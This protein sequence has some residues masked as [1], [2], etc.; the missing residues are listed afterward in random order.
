[1]VSDIK[2]GSKLLV[3]GEWRGEMEPWEEG[4]WGWDMLWEE[5]GWGG[6]RLWEEGGWG[7]DRLWE[8][9]GWGG[10]LCIKGAAGER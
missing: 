8:E 2:D 10:D 6:D 1:M 3:G 7:G 5:R 4:G 9:G